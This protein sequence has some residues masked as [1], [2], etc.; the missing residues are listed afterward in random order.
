[1]FGFFKKKQP[2]AEAPNRPAGH[3]NKRHRHRGG[4][5]R[6][7]DGNRDFNRDSSDR[8][9]HGDGNRDRG[10]G[11]GHGHGGHGGHGQAPRPEPQ[12]SLRRG[13]PAKASRITTEMNKSADDD[14]VYFGAL[15]GLGE[16]GCNLY[17]Y[18]TGGDWIIVDIGIGFPD[19]RMSGAESVIPDTTFLKAI[20]NR[21]KGI[22]ITHS[23]YDH[24][25][26]IP[27]IW[28]E[29]GCPV[30]GTPFALGMLER[31]LEE[32]GILGKVELHRIPK[33]GD[34]FQIG[35]FDIEYMHVTHSIPQASFLI[36][37]TKQGV[38]FHSG[39]FKFDPTPLIDEPTDLDRLSE[40]GREG[41]ACVMCDSTNAIEHRSERSEKTARDEIEKEI[42]AIR[43]GK[44]VITCFATNIA[45]V[46]TIAEVARRLGKKLCVVGR[47]IES[48]IQIAKDVGYMEGVE[49]ISADEAKK[50]PDQEVVYLCTGTQGEPR[51]QVTRL[52]ED[53]SRS[54]SLASGDTVI[55]SSR[56]IPGNEK[57]IFAVQNELVRRGIG[58]ISTQTN[59]MIHASGHA[60]REE[61]AEL[62]KRIKPASVIPI[63][64]EFMHM[65]ANAGIAKEMGLET[66]LIENGQFVAI[67]K[68]KSPEIVET[69]TIESVILDGTM[70]LTEDDAVFEARRD[71]SENGA[72]FISFALKN[73]QIYGKPRISSVGVFESDATGTIKALLLSEV[74]GAIARLTKKTL[75]NEKEI[76]VAVERAI[77]RMAK[78]HTGKEPVVEVHVQ[79]A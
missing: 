45:R 64:G 67:E 26:A 59:P 56:I 12:K 52:A 5:G 36:L 43:S 54:L 24:F 14:R 41:V 69:I 68:G 63:H 1:M 20:K 2:D 22:F 7:V 66:L 46:S 53:S 70:R 35:A 6:E 15:G 62:Y 60:T 65:N 61:I 30:Y 37:R 72:L 79:K 51:A 77:S 34:R 71:A 47:S 29:I 38:I 9:R 33:E 50:L 78:E 25:S 3:N 28:G 27:Q 39:D 10:R 23:H 13:N 42:K 49:I 74:K 31:G 16:F 8:G 18:G 32:F 76:G 55:F 48:N 17:L 75:E 4:K 73:G 57:Q 21:I 40:I 58:V 44:V 19:E 11:R